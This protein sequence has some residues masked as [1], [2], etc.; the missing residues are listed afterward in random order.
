MWISTNFATLRERE[1]RFEQ[2][3]SVSLEALFMVF[4]LDS[5]SGPRRGDLLIELLLLPALPLLLEHRRVLVLPA[6]LVEG[7]EDVSTALCSSCAN[8]SFRG[9]EEAFGQSTLPPAA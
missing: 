4:L 5:K 6:R 9:G 8:D 1:I 2:L 7:R 3:R